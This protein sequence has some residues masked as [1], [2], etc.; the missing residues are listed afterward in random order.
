MSAI[1]ASPLS[2]EQV[3]GLANL[4]QPLQIRDVVMRNRIV[5]SPMCQYSAIDGVAND[6]HLVHL[7]SRAVGGA[8]LV[9]VEAT[10]VEARGRISL[11]DLGLWNDQQEAALARIATFLKENGAVAGIQ[12]AHA[13]R[14][15]S[16]DVPWRGGAPLTPETGSWPIVAPSAI[17]FAPGYDVPSA[18]SVE[19]TREIVRAFA[20]SARRAL[21]AGFQVIEIHGAHGY[22]INEFL[23]PLSNKRSDDYGGSF[24]N[25]IRFLLEIIDAVRNEWPETL[26][27]WLRISATD[28][29]PG[30]WTIGDSV[31]L[32]N[33]VKTR[34]VD[35]IDCSSG[36]LVPN[37]KIPVG[38]GYQVPLAEQ[39]RR[40]ARILTG[41]VGMIEDPHQAA[42]IIREN[43][44]DVV[45]LAREFLRQPY[46]PISAANALGVDFPVPV[47]YARAFPPKR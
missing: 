9:M 29:V 2:A 30:G 31:M 15:A 3:S 22:L 45:L 41:A 10:G 1:E 5:V 44:A 42:E 13:G 16:T 17:P 20:S 12:L 47:Q 19:E 26:P 23:S 27:L 18:L 7:G 40:E 28:W 43:K 39:V 35:L 34:G 25:R 4:F 14:K 6:W 24:E 8:G 11:G 21:R 38:P 36:A 33:I 32:A 46:W 37:A